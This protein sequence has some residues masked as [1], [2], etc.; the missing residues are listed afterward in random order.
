MKRLGRLTV[1]GGTDKW[2][3]N[4]TAT[5]EAPLEHARQVK[6]YAEENSRLGCYGKRASRLLDI[7]HRIGA[8]RKT[9]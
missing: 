9:Q 3:H 1:N 2:K 8:S 6:G 5:R 4:F 7:C